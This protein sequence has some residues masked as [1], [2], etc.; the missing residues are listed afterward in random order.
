MD[1]YAGLYINFVTMEE[2]RMKR[3]DAPGTE[4]TEIKQANA[5]VFTFF[6][7]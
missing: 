5:K 3:N 2:Y 1:N 6:V 4:K 7:D